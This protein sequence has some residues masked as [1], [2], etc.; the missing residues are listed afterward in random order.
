MLSDFGKKFLKTYFEIFEEFWFYKGELSY[1]SQ[2]I[3]DKQIKKVT[4]NF[5]KDSL[6]FKRKNR[7]FKLNC[8]ISLHPQR[9]E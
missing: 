6:T 2:L 7:W 8:K 1:D 9:L 4:Q 5:L 3:K